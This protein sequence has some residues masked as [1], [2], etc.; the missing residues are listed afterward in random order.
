MVENIFIFQ[1]LWFLGVPVGAINV[2][3]GKYRLSETLKEHPEWTEEANAFL[4][5]YFLYMTVPFFLL[6]LFQ[7]AGGY[8]DPF[9]V[10]MQDIGIYQVLAWITLFFFWYRAFHYIFFQDGAKQLVKF[11]RV[12]NIPPSETLIKIL[13]ILTLFVAIFA[14]LM[15]YH[16]GIGDFL[17]Q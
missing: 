4:K 10:V 6:G 16:L 5:G 9:Y 8:K 2:L 3:W 1:Y 14:F 17:S 12:G 11:N 13:T 15:A 7:Y